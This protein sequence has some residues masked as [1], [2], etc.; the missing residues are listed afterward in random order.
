[1]RQNSTRKRYSKPN[2][3]NS[4]TSNCFGCGK[5][6]HIK[7]DCPNNQNKEKP[8]SKKGERSKGRRAYISW[9]DNEV[10]SSSDSSTESETE[11]IVEPSGVQALKN[12]NPLKDVEGLAVLAVAELS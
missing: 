9:E 5:P 1:M 6:G 8:A 2:E 7:V 11:N 12:P 4:S 10:S 3:S